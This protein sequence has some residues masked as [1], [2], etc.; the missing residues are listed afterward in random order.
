MQKPAV[1]TQ[2][3]GVNKGYTSTYIGLAVFILR[4]E[5]VTV[6]EKVV[7]WWVFIVQ[8]ETLY[9]WSAVG[10]ACSFQTRSFKHFGTTHVRLVNTAV[11]SFSTWGKRSTEALSNCGTDSE[12]FL[13]VSSFAAFREQSDFVFLAPVE[14][15]GLGLLVPHPLSPQLSVNITHCYGGWKKVKKIGTECILG[16]NH[17]LFPDFVWMMWTCFAT[18]GPG[19]T[20]KSTHPCSCSL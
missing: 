8:R 18:L 13:L 5:V 9:K 19:S 20:V 3:L 15:Q 4:E 11:R 16:L 2:Q 17:T 1:S 6:P 10:V 7:K 12:G 14:P